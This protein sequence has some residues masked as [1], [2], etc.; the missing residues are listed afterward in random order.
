MNP[1]RP[2]VAARTHGDVPGQQVGDLVVGGVD[3]DV[4]GHVGGAALSV[5]HAQDELVGG[6]LHALVSGLDVVHVAVQ[7]VLVGEGGW[8]GQRGGVDEGECPW[9]GFPWSFTNLMQTPSY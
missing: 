6:G 4:E 5:G 2:C 7:D 3:D 8:W 9:L 1:F